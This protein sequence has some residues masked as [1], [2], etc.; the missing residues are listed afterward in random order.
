MSIVSSIFWG[1]PYIFSYLLAINIASFA[2]FGFDKYF[3][4][5]SYSRVR[6]KT[7]LLLALAGGS[8]GA[9]GSI[10]LFRHKTR[11]SPFLI[12]LSCITLAHVGLLLLWL[13]YMGS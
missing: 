4:I 6:E 12:M 7:L 2:W 5:F 1:Q 8:I 9:W 10:F 3:A 11:K 13:R